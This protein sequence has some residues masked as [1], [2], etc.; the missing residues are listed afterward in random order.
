MCLTL[1]AS[2]KYPRFGVM[3]PPLNEIILVEHY[4]KFYWAKTEVDRC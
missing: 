3:Q 2:P 4:A 1:Q